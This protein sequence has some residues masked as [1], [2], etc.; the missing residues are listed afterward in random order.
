MSERR[1]RT[2]LILLLLLTGCSHSPC[3]AP[4][5]TVPPPLVQVTVDRPPCPL[6][7]L[8]APIQLGGTAEQG[9]DRVLVTRAALADLG[10]Y[11]EG[12]RSWIG[13]ASTCLEV[14]P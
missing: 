7:A 6:P 5:R 12:L 4:P 14:T 9:G 10:A 13:A 11:L 3:P 1:S 8:P 2:P